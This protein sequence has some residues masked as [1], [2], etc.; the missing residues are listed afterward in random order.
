MALLSAVEFCN[1]RMFYEYE[2]TG[3]SSSAFRSII[4]KQLRGCYNGAYIAIIQHRKKQDL[5][6]EQCNIE[7][8]KGV[9]GAAVGRAAAGAAG[10]ISIQNMFTHIPIVAIR[11]IKTVLSRLMATFVRHN[12][13]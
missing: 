5:P 2:T 1:V 7:A 10:I 3:M 4:S 13:S 11:L 8:W 9:A 12:V 6:L